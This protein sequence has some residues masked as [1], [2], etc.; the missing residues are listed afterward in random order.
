[1]SHTRT[2]GNSE[3]FAVLRVYGTQKFSRPCHVTETILGK[4][5]GM[6]SYLMRNCPRCKYFLG[7]V[8]KSRVGKAARP[9]RGVCVRC[10]YQLS[11]KLIPGGL[12]PLRRLEEKLRARKRIPVRRTTF[13]MS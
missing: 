10:C 13:S 5:I 4:G 7:V 2:D 8:V 9:I 11:W 1:M 6:A 12:L 3:I